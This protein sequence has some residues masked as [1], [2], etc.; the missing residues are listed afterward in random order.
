ML[1]HPLSP[2]VFLMKDDKN[3]LSEYSINKGSRRKY[4]SYGIYVLCTKLVVFIP[5]NSKGE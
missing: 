3:F 1:Y 2:K 4:E 5:F